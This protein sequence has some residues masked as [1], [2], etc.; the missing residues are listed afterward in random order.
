ML[1]PLSQ[2]V[3]DFDMHITGIL[4]VGAHTCEELEA[5]QK[6]LSLTNDDIYWVEGQLSLVDA[7]KQN[8]PDCKIFHAVVSD[9]DDEKV[10]FSVTNNMQSS[11]I[12]ELDEHL[13]EHPHV[14]VTHCESVV[15]TRLDTL[16]TREKIDMTHVNFLNL[17]IQ[18]AE[19][20]ALKGLGS[21]LTKHIRYIYTEV[22]IKHLYKNCALLSDLDTFLGDAGFRRVTL[23]MTEHGWGDAL[24]CKNHDAIYKI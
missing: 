14:F 13:K 6:E 20:L 1:I 12:L 4:H 10:S 3:K 8:I 23:K 11:S 17:D 22:N 15:T 16:L 19:L 18:G 7:A 24:Y 9:V 2:I 5:Y 21:Y